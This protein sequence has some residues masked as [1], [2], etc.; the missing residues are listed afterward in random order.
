M[1]TRT[2]IDRLIAARPAAVGRTEDV[3]DAAAED[4]ILQ[5]ILTSGEGPAAQAACRRLARGG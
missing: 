4:R 3:V 2:E 1:S 5:Q